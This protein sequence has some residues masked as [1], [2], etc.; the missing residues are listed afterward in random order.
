M[1]AS[2]AV[3]TLRQEIKTLETEINSLNDRIKDLINEQKTYPERW[4]LLQEEILENKRL[5]L[6]NKRQITEK[7]T[8]VELITRQQFTHKRGPPGQP[9]EERSSK[10]SRSSS[11]YSAIDALHGKPARDLLSNSEQVGVRTFFRYQ[12]TPMV[13]DLI[14]TA[15]SS[16]LGLINS[17][18]PP[19]E[20]IQQHWDDFAQVLFHNH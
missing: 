18:H 7:Q 15:L 17:S 11:S 20:K 4:N 1:A 5:A 13:Q 9:T 8:T 3:D 12:P 19:E 16:T 10:S 2:D 6:E 14:R